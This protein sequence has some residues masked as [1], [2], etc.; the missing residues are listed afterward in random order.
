MPSYMGDA[1]V[2]HHSPHVRHQE[3]VHRC[4]RGADMHLEVDMHRQKVD[5]LG[6]KSVELANFW[7][8]R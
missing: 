8:L 5:K 3:E 4:N 7:L 6:D 2:G 1:L